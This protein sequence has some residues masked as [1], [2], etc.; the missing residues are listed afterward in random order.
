MITLVIPMKKH[1][2]KKH[3]IR[4]DAISSDAAVQ[5]IYIMRKDIP[6]NAGEA[7]TVKVE[8]NA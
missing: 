8:Y 5:S 2:D 1:S 3:S 4:Y 7:I 6:A